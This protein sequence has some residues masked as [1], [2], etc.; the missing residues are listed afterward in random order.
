MESKSLSFRYKLRVNPFYSYASFRFAR[1][2]AP[3]GAATCQCV[4]L[5]HF[6]FLFFSMI[7]RIHF[8]LFHIMHLFQLTF[9]VPW[10]DHGTQLYRVIRV[11]GTC[12]FA[13]FLRRPPYFFILFC[14]SLCSRTFF[15]HSSIQLLSILLLILEN[16]VNCMEIEGRD[17]IK[18]FSQVKGPMEKKKENRDHANK[19]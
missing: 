14:L 10:L 7:W 2:R 3:M 6:N 18:K 17:P 9:I 8:Y 16:M 19:I 13:I 11:L 15:M 4:L 12:T 5:F 1:L